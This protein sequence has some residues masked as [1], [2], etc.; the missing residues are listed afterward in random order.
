LI[1]SLGCGLDG[2]GILYEMPN[3]RGWGFVGGRFA[4]ISARLSDF[5]FH[6][7]GL[8]TLIDFFWYRKYGKCKANDNPYPSGLRIGKDWIS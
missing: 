5:R 3:P 7:Q 6:I 2:S 1:P 8:P 4:N